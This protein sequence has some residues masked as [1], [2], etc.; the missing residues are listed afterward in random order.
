ME[1]PAMTELNYGTVT[2]KGA[3]DE[4]HFSSFYCRCSAPV[5]VNL[6]IKLAS[7]DIHFLKQLFTFSCK[8]RQSLM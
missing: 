8:N 7:T 1:K 6:F 3:S 4:K 5:K 2:V